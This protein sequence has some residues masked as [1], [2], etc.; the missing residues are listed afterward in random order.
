MSPAVEPDVPPVDGPA[1]A[2]KGAL[3]IGAAPPSVAPPAFASPAFEPPAFEP[4]P[5]FEAFV[6][7]PRFGMPSLAV[8]ATGD[9]Q[10]SQDRG[11]RPREGKR[12]G[13][14]HSFL[15][16]VWDERPLTS[17]SSTPKWV[18]QRAV[19]MVQRRDRRCDAI[20]A[21]RRVRTPAP[22]CPT[23]DSRLGLG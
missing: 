15:V 18:N 22:A 21:T 3:G 10:R 6:A 14:E 12:L 9:R 7:P 1:P 11:Q 13:S 8:A 17:C 4:P 5:G 2:T 20:R 23:Q 16:G 19:S